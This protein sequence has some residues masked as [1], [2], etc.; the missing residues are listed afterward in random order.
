M[1]TKE[2]KESLDF[3]QELTGSK[4]TLGN[5]LLAIRQGE[6]MSQV[7]FAKQLHITRQYL[8][9]IEHGRRFISPKMA[10]EYA[11]ILGYS[12]TQFVRLCLQDMLDRDG[13]QMKID[14]ENAA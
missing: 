10:A 14:V 1:I 4:L 2:T 9:D 8:C 3:L 11:D 13:L 6:E 7:D 5:F 12:K